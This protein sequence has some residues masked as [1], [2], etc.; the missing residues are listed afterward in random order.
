MS[1]ALPASEI[2]IPP[3]TNRQLSISEA[4]PTKRTCQLNFVRERSAI[5]ARRAHKIREQPLRQGVSRHALRVPLNPNDPVRVARPFDALN[6][7]VRSLRR[8]A[9][10]FPRSVNCLMMATVDLCLGPLI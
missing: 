10:V 4:C 9:K 7:S 8:N 1:A 6:G 3:R 2:M 5:A